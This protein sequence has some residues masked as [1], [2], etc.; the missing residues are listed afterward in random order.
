MEKFQ[1]EYRIPSARAKWWDYSS[2]GIYFVTICTAGHISYFGKIEN[3]E[4]V[5]SEIGALALEEWNKSFTIRKELFCDVFVIMPN[6]IH[7]ILQIENGRDA[8][9][10]RDARPFASAEHHGIAYRTPKSISSF[11]AGFKTA[12]TTKARKIHAGFEWQ[13]RFYDHIIRMDAEYQRIAEYIENNP[14]NWVQDKF[15]RS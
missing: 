15:Y 14:A 10:G 11:V 12:A 9:S 7:A 3:K 13:T 4:V 6:H 5:L 8:Q 1:N 2:T